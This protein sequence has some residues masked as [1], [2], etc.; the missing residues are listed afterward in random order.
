MV[1]S[2]KE[3][4]VV[5][6][7][8]E[9][10]LLQKRID[11]TGINRE[12]LWAYGQHEVP[13]AYN[14]LSGQVEALTAPATELEKATWKAAFGDKWI[15]GTADYVGT[16]IDLPWVDD[17]KTG[18]KADYSSYRYQQA[19]YSLAW[20]LCNNDIAARST[21]THWPKYPLSQKPSRFGVMLEPEFFLK[22]QGK[23]KRLYEVVMKNK[24]P[25]KELDSGILSTGEHCVY[26]PSKRNCVKGASYESSRNI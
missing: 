21:I 17:L 4:G 13:L 2:W 1:H 18:R 14:V 19:F 23:L 24:E 10:K 8:R 9:G 16:L 7:G 12:E 3:T 25:G 6:E 11:A 15:T 22:F 5:P 20:A 26:C